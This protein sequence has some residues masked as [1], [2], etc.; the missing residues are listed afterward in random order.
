MVK[1]MDLNRTLYSSPY[2]RGTNLN[3]YVDMDEQT[4][5]SDLQTML[6]DLFE[7]EIASGDDMSLEERLEAKREMASLTGQLTSKDQS[8]VGLKPKRLHQPYQHPKKKTQC[9]G[10]RLL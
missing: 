2:T 9:R 1:I 3:Y 6:N 8:C 10:S 4:V 5:R 7:L